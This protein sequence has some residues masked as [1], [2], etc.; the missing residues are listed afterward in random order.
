[1]VVF[2]EAGVGRAVDETK[3]NSDTG[4]LGRGGREGGREGRVRWMSL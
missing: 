4:I 2:T 1:M 3:N